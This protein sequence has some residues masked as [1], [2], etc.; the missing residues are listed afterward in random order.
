MAQPPSKQKVRATLVDY[1]TFILTVSP[2]IN[3]FTDLPKKGLDNVKMQN[4]TYFNYVGNKI[5]TQEFIKNTRAFILVEINKTVQILL[6]FWRDRVNG[7]F[8]RRAFG[9][10]FNKPKCN[11]MNFRKSLHTQKNRKPTIGRNNS[12][13]LRSALKY[14]TPTPVGCKLYVAKCMHNGAD[15]VGIL[16]HGAGKKPGAYIPSIDRRVKRGMWCGI[17]NKYWYRW[18]RV[19]VRELYKQEDLMNKRIMKH[20]IT[21][22]IYLSTNVNYRRPSQIAYIR[23]QEERKMTEW[24]LKQYNLPRVTE[25]SK[26]HEM[27]VEK[28]HNPYMGKDI[29]V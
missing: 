7:Y 22:G 4:G 13:K 1:R 23:R 20:M 21:Q 16:I 9:I 5:P 17:T 18:W 27:M 10:Q 29:R 19:F 26:G 25:K 24:E 28:G 15:Y 12:G 2:D 3:P 11:A 8:N 14:T 6:K